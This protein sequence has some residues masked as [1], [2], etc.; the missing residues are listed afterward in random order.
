MPHQ[1]SDLFYELRLRFLS[2]GQQSSALLLQTPAESLDLPTVRKVVHAWAGA[3]GMLGCPQITT[4][5]RIIEQ[6]IREPIDGSR[7][8]IWDALQTSHQ[9]FSQWIEADS[10]SKPIEVLS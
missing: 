2:E 6:L 10:R 8:S 5:A 9:V 3:G 1:S 4:Q 7:Q